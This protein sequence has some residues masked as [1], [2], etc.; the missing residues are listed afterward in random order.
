MERATEPS[1]R[2]AL[3]ADGASLRYIPGPELLG[4]HGRYVGAPCSQSHLAD[5]P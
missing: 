4:P 3:I 1:E 2:D 5:V